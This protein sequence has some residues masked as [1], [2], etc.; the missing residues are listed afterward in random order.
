MT[1]PSLQ[2]RAT[3]HDGASEG[4]LRA[5]RYAPPRWKAVLALATVLSG[6]VVATADSAPQSTGHVTL[7]G[8]RAQRTERVSYAPRETKA[9]PAGPGVHGVVVVSGRITVYGTSEVQ[10]VYGQGQGFAAGWAPYWVANET[11]TPAETL[12]TWHVRP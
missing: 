5:R 1:D 12:L 4:V 8:L 6:T 9:W 3:A 11:G 2:T 10:R 7:V